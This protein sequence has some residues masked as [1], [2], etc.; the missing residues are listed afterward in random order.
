MVQV[1]PESRIA[2]SVLRSRSDARDLQR[3]IPIWVEDQNTNDKSAV[4]F[5]LSVD[6]D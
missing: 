5:F 2:I 4:F 1:A 3:L 6:P